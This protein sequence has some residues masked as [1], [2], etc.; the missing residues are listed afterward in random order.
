MFE[1]GRTKCH[2]P[3]FQGGT[4]NGIQAGYP[5]GMSEFNQA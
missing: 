1:A 3:E 4:G 5:D 2:S